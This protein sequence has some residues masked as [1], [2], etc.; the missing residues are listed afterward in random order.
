MM[1][2]VGRDLTSIAG[3]IVEYGAENEARNHERGQYD[4]S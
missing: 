4:E 2:A 1:S 3:D